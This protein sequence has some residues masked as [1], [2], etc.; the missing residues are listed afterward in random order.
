MAVGSDG[1]DL[2][3]K[4]MHQNMVGGYVQNTF[5]IRSKYVCHIFKILGLC[6]FSIKIFQEYEAKYVSQN[7]EYVVKNTQKLHIF[8][9]NTS[10]IHAIASHSHVL[11]LRLCSQEYQI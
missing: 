2:D 11:L 6:A 3:Y 8:E 5:K 9:Q 7:L 10:K 4:N 1:I